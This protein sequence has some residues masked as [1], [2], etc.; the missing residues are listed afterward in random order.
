MVIKVQYHSS[1]LTFSLGP[2]TAFSDVSGVSPQAIECRP[3]SICV[4]TLMTQPTMISHSSQKP[5]WAPVLVVAISSP[6]PTIEPG[7]DHARAEPGK[8]SE[9]SLGRRLNLGRRQAS[10]G[11]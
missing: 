6:E 7:Q 8:R 1:Q 9:Q 11:R 10:L 2:G 3:N 4:E 5:A